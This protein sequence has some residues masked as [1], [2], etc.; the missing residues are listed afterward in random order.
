MF[1]NSLVSNTYSHLSSCLSSVLPHS[2]LAPVNHTSSERW[3]NIGYGIRKISYPDPQC[4]FMGGLA[5]WGSVSRFEIRDKDKAAA[6]GRGELCLCVIVD[7]SC[8]GTQPLI[9]FTFSFSVTFANP[10][11]ASPHNILPVYPPRRHPRC[12]SL[13]LI[14]SCTFTPFSFTPT[15]FPSLPFC[16]PPHP[17]FCLLALHQ[18]LLFIFMQHLLLP[19]D[20]PAEVPL[21]WQREIPPGTPPRIPSAKFQKWRRAFL[22]RNCSTERQL[23]F[24]S[25]C[26]WQSLMAKC[27]G[28]L[29]KWAEF[30]RPL[31]QPLIG[32]RECEDTCGLAAV[33]SRPW[34][35][36]GGCI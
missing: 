2:I 20:L 4:F 1:G 30:A 33:P 29:F 27:Q 23:G 36:L 5:G 8:G 9:V 15:L 32:F 17:P 35:G 34:E 22:Q 25:R 16:L 24:F 13:L 12:H 11:T 28:C 31:P 19:A 21:I 7:D 6:A 18:Q 14:T 10:Q 26:R 3:L